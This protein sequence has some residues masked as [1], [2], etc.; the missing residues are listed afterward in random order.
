MFFY[1]GCTQWLRGGP[2]RFSVSILYDPVK[3]AQKQPLRVLLPDRKMI[4][5]RELAS[6]QG[7]AVGIVDLFFTSH[8][9]KWNGWTEGWTESATSVTRVL[10]VT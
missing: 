6:V 9:I 5:L 3:C 8:D 2:S 1:D 10:S 4:F 7:G